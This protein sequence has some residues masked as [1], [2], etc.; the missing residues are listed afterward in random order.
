[1]FV[2]DA[3]GEVDGLSM[4]PR[5][6]I[7]GLLPAILASVVLAFPGSASS[8]TCAGADLMPTNNNAVALRDATLCLLNIERTSR[9]LT[10]LATN[11]QLRRVAQNY[12]RA[13]VR[14]RFFDHVSPGG[15]TLLSRVRRGT[16]YLHGAHQ[17]ALGENIAWGSGDYATPRETV[18]SWM[19]SRGH[20]L[21]ILNRS[22]RHIGV[23]V[24]IG[25]P[26][27]AQGMPAA[28][29]TTDFGERSMR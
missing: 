18:K 1:V 27:D 11:T 2:L 23:G 10:P 29:Y 28:T 21:N 5:T 19:E 22:F 16:V 4:A 14:E 6:L 25:A 26:E 15:S 12:S 13:M 17:F 9:G 7:R 20:R 24:A 3:A 8:A